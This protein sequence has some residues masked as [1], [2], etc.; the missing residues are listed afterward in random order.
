M[1]KIIDCFIFYNEINMLNMR[2]HELNNYV[3]YFLLVES[4]KTFS[5]NPKTLF[6]QDNKELFKHFNHKII[7]YIV[8]DMDSIKAKSA[9]DRESHQRNCIRRAL[10]ENETM[11]QDQDIIL[12]SDVDEIPNPKVFNQ[13]T[14]KLIN[15]NIPRL[16]LCQRF[17]YYNFRCENKDKFRNNKSRNTIA[18]T[19]QNLKKVS[20]QYLRGRRGTIHRVYNGGWHCSYFGNSQQIINKIR[21]FSHQEYNSDKYLDEKKID[22]HILEGSDLFDRKH[23]KWEF[24]DIENDDNLPKFKHLLINKL[25]VP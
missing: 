10:N 23:E 2:L 13:I 7:H 3:D 19:Y 6:Y 9:W 14:D 21:Q 11:I 18:I 24:N 4:T 25:L 1:T 20:P 12:Y 16:V 5:N 17:F 22:N 8:D 15:Q